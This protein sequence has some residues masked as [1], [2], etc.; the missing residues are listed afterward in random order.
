MIARL[1]SAQDCIACFAVP[2]ATGVFVLSNQLS[3]DW[4]EAPSG[5]MTATT[6]R[7]R[8]CFEGMTSANEE[9]KDGEK[10][11]RKPMNGEN[12]LTW[13]H[14]LLVIVPYEEPQR[15]LRGPQRHLGGGSAPFRIIL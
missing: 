3:S 10:T 12:S 1:R 14:S 7:G 11:R 8:V 5:T 6:A 13:F 2:F 15:Q 4:A 9:A